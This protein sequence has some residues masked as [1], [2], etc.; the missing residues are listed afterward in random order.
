MAGDCWEVGSYL[1]MVA[2]MEKY[3]MPYSLYH[4]IDSGPHKTILLCPFVTPTVSSPS[5]ASHARF[6]D[7]PVPLYLRRKRLLIQIEALKKT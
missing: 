6:K 7:H 5:F 2:R 4:F 1:M 3:T